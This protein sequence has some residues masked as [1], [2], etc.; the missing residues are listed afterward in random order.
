MRSS[1]GRRR[2]ATTP[3]PAPAPARPASYPGGAA[4]VRFRTPRSTRYRTPRGGCLR[5]TR[6]KARGGP[7][8]AGTALATLERTSL[9]GAIPADRAL[10]PS[11]RARV[12]TRPCQTMAGQTMAGQTMGKLIQARIE[13]AI[14]KWPISHW[15]RERGGQAARRLPAEKWQKVPSRNVPRPG[16]PPIEL[17]CKS[18]AGGTRE[19]DRSLRRPGGRSP[20]S[21]QPGRAGTGR[22]EG[23]GPLSR[24]RRHLFTVKRQNQSPVLRRTF[25][26]LRPSPTLLQMPSKF[27]QTFERDERR[28]ILGPMQISRTRKIQVIANI[29]AT[30]RQAKEKES[31]P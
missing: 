1:C 21:L 24:R 11:A 22:P 28:N 16:P 31:P 6:W 19:W 17:P 20:P 12:T 10:G 23:E 3:A 30:K 26:R 29:I 14:E 9:R 13:Q 4:P 15:G 8:R 7:R 27:S 25:L 18:T 2:T 5:T